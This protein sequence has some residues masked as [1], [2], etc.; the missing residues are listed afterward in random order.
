MGGIIARYRTG[1]HANVNWW[2]GSWHDCGGHLVFTDLVGGKGLAVTSD[3]T[4]IKSGT[5]HSRCQKSG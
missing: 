5:T 3:E 4:V 2:Y 1:I